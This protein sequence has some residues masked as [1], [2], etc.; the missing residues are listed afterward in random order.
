MAGQA[1]PMLTE[2]AIVNG[3]DSRGAVIYHQPKQCRCAGFLALTTIINIA[4]NNQ[5]EGSFH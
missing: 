5:L 2:T 4:K 3:K 1:V